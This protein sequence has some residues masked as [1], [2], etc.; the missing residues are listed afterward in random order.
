MQ[1]TPSISPAELELTY[2]KG[3]QKLA[4]KLIRASKGM[5]NKSLGNAFQQEAIL[6]IRQVLDEHTKRKRPV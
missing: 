1:Q 4:G 6:E 5:S 3:L 2:A